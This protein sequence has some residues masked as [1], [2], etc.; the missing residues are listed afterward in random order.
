MKTYEIHLAVNDRVMR[1]WKFWITCLAGW[2][3][4]FQTIKQMDGI[5]ITVL[6]ALQSSAC[7][8]AITIQH[9]YLEL[10]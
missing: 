4:V 5:V 9:C 8:W 10:F 1:Q 6:S 3:R 2:S 7:R